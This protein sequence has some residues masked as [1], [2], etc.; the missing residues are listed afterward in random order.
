MIKVAMILL[1]IGHD[2][3]DHTVVPELKFYTTFSIKVISNSSTH[4]EDGMLS[5]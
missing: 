1:V 4:W 2:K 3:R 5:A